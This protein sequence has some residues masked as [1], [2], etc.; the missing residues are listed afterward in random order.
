MPYKNPQ[1]QKE[2]YEKNKEKLIALSR[3]NYA[4]NRDDRIKKC[5][6]RYKKIRHTIITGEGSGHGRG[7]KFTKGFTPW[8]KGLKG[9]QTAWNKGKKD[10][11]S[12]S[13][14]KSRKEKMKGKTPWNK[15][16]KSD[17]YGDKHYNWKGG[18]TSLNE[19]CR[20]SVEYKLWRKSVLERDNW[21]CQKYGKKGGN[22][23]AHHINNFSEFIELRTAINNGITL[24]DKAHKEF[25]KKYG[26]KNNTKQ[27]LEE[28]LKDND[29]IVHI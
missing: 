8:N 21:T 29:Y 19:K 10:F 11:I 5:R 1:K 6:E 3:L 23:I 12:E 16:K 26:I 15:G 14:K 2:Y 7:K 9:A 13:G 17:I 4:E 20:K 24:S 22:L 28:F 27:Q 25:H 18:I